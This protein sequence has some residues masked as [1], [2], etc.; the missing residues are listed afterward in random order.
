MLQTL[1]GLSGYYLLVLKTRAATGADSSSICS[2]VVRLQD[3]VEKQ[4]T[5]NF[6]SRLLDDIVACVCDKPEPDP[7]L[8]RVEV[9]IISAISS[10]ARTR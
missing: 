3:E 8:H 4:G 1:M 7:P 9:G 10:L 2:C 6:I 5:F